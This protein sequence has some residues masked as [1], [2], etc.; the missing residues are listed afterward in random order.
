[1]KITSIFLL[2]VLALLSSSGNCRPNVEGRKPVCVD[3][4]GCHKIYDP[5]CG[6]DGHTY[7]NECTLCHDNKERRSPVLIQ[8]EGAC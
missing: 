4:V 6:S 8:K 7:P 5:V 3:F 1:M 2:T